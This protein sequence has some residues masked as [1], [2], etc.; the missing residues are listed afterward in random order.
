[1]AVRRLRVAI[2]GGGLGGLACGIGLRQA[3][4]EVRVFER[5]ADAGARA[6]GVVL[7]LE[8]GLSALDR[9]GLGEAVRAVGFPTPGL[10][11]LDARMRPLIRFPAK[12]SFSVARPALR[13]LLL[14]ALG[15]DAIS[16]GRRSTGFEEGDEGV[17]VSFE[18]GERWGADVLVGADGVRSVV[19]EQR[20]G[21]PLE[22]R[23]L[24]ILGNELTGE[25]V[26]PWAASPWL[27]EGKSILLSKHGS[28]Y[29]TLYSQ[30]RRL[31]WSFGLPATEEEIEALAADPAGLAG[32]AARRA[33][34]W[35]EPV[36]SLVAASAGHPFRLRGVYD[37]EPLPAAPPGRVTLLG[38]A[39]HPMTP[40]RGLGANLAFEDA[41][42]LAEMLSS[43][44]GAA[45]PVS[46][47]AAYERTMAPRG[48]S[49]QQ[50]SRWTAWLL[51]F[52]NPAACAARN[53]WLRLA[54]RVARV[55]GK[56]RGRSGT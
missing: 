19:R 50:A 12:D 36:P 34:Q 33:A 44:E 8:G 10:A 51:H 22:F 41:A 26:E 54:Q 20:H 48:T 31:H 7:N 38:D 1:M 21:D 39:A 30:E 56:K 28:F 16:W 5:D 9:L 35:P 43:P 45:D 15:P 14:E 40:Y 49:A 18:D 23:R 29:V 52:Q 37:R 27:A 55:V 17:T 53:S 24:M 4:H 6:Q 11:V 46:A 25:A 42:D 13:G 47:L 32:E 2:V 3:G